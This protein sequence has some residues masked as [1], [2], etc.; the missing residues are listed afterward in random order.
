[1]FWR[2]VLW[3]GSPMETRHGLKAFRRQQKSS[4]PPNLCITPHPPLL[5]HHPPLAWVQLLQKSSGRRAREVAT[6]RR[7]VAVTCCLRSFLNCWV[8]EEW[9]WW[10]KV[11]LWSAVAI[12]IIITTL[13][14]S[15]LHLP[16]PARRNCPASQI[17]PPAPLQLPSRRLKIILLL[18]HLSP[19]PLSICPP[20]WENGRG[21]LARGPTVPCLRSPPQHTAR[22]TR[23]PKRVEKKGSRRTRGKY[24]SWRSRTSVWRQRSKGWERRYRRHGELWLRG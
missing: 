17:L 24:K 1:M 18:P 20:D 19:L 6:A 9:E 13:I 11:E 2:V 8:K 22:P 12:I 15:I 10:I 5:H 3:C 16:Q 23:L 14:T 7:E 21:P 4:T